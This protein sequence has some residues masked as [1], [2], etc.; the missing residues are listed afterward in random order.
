MLIPLVLGVFGRAAGQGGGSDRD[1]RR[2]AK[3]DRRRYR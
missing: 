3:R 1:A 2:A